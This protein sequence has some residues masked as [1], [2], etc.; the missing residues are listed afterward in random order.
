MRRDNGLDHGGRFN[1]GAIT[2]KYRRQ[3]AAPTESWW[4][5]PAEQFAEK[6][7]EQ[8]PRLLQ[9]TAAMVYQ[10]PKAHADQA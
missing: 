2:P 5:V 10:E 4:L 6:A 1:D 7:R 9:V 8:L 3:S